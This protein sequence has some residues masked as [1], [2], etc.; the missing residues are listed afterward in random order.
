[1]R[2]L[3]QLQRLRRPALRPALRAYAQGPDEAA[4]PRDGGWVEL[5]DVEGER[6]YGRGNLKLW[7]AEPTSGSASAPAAGRA[8]AG[9]RVDKDAAQP[10]GENGPNLRAELRGF[11]F[12]GDPPGVGASLMVRPE[13]EQDFYPVRV[14]EVESSDPNSGHV[15]LDWPDERL[16]ASLS[17]LGGL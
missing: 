8:A 9:G 1:M 4:A 5:W 3:R 7:P 6:R 2:R 12:D 17:E 14:L 13:T 10:V 11:T 16:P 15:T